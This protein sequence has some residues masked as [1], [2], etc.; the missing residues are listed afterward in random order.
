MPNLRTLLVLG[1]L[2]AGNTFAAQAAPPPLL[3]GMGRWHHRI[4][5]KDPLVQRY[6]DQG[7]AL[8]YGFNHDEAIRDFRYAAQRDPSCAMCWW[9]VALALGP[10]IN[11]PGVEQDREQRALAA[12]EKARA[13]ADVPPEEK[14]YVDAV[15]K[16]YA[17]APSDRAALDRA[18]AAAMDALAHAYPGDADA[19]VLAAEAKMDLRPWRLWSSDGKPAPGTEEIV[20]SLAAVLKVHPQHPGANHFYIH[21][22]ESSPHP[23]RAL[24]A[25]KRLPNLMPG[26]GHIVHMPAHI[27]MRVGRY[28]LA[29]KANEQA[30]RV[31]R[32]YLAVAHP[33]GMYP[34]MY[35]AHN[36]Q[37][38]WAAA[39][40]E[41]NSKKAVAAAE[42]L[43]AR[44]PPD[45]LAMMLQMMPGMDFFIAPT[46]MVRIRFGQWDA[47]LALP[48]P[49]ATEPYLQAMW[50]YGRAIAFA[51]KAQPDQ[52]RAEQKA[53]DTFV[54]SVPVDAEL[55][56][57]NSARAV[58]AVA[59]ASLA[60]ELTLRTVSAEAAIPLFERAVKA[61][62]ALGYDE[63][64]PWFLSPRQEL[65]FALLKAKRPAEAEA[66]YRADLE[67]YR[68]NG[69]SL[70]GLREALAAQKKPTAE[71]ARRFQR[72][73]ANAD[74]ELTGSIF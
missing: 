59:Q 58:M 13:I 27:Y 69:W 52:A 66:V 9:G 30:I 35:V 42:A 51:A 33:E 17:P 73:W 54:A 56:P 1:A 40:M 14:A 16:R 21:A 61:E 43:A 31:D 34:T 15:A 48:D 25:A 53:F 68:E 47:L 50:H 57:L 62:D 72:A 5:T 70:F 60:G 64:P 44:F 74:V 10:N 18:Y 12:I 49:G 8:V 37:F 39:A 6:F 23:E 36:F 67:R 45:V 28:D 65:G 19:Q 7:L 3:S 55:G 32:A 24:E 29:V 11:M 63:P 2:F 38:L 71:V 4:S 46:V 26:A 22:L 41:G 20:D